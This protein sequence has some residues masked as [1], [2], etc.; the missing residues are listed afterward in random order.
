MLDPGSGKAA[1]DLGDAVTSFI[2]TGD[3]GA[4]TLMG[5]EIPASTATSQ[6]S[7]QE[8]RS[9]LIER[10]FTRLETLRD[11]LLNV[12]NVALR[13]GLIV[14]VTTLIREA[15]GYQL[16]LAWD[17]AD[18]TEATQAWASAAA[19]MLGPAMNVLG[20]VRDE[21]NGTGNWQTRIGRICLCSMTM[22]AT[23]AAY[24]GGALNDLFV[25]AMKVNIY[26]LL[27]EGMNAFFPLND[28]AGPSGLPAASVAM[29]GYGV[30]QTAL[31]EVSALLPIS[32]AGRAAAG[33]G[34]S[35][36]ADIWQSVLNAFGA[37]ADDTIESL[38]RYLLPV[39]SGMPDSL[40]DHVE[41]PEGWSVRAGALM[42]GSDRLLSRVL[43]ASPARISA[44]QT[45][46]ASLGAAAVALAGS[47]ADENAQS[48]LL[49]VAVGV[50][51]MLIYVPFIFSMQQ[52]S[53][54]WSPIDLHEVQ[55]P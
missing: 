35:L 7:L 36:T 13:T 20:F 40:P 30:M 31:A 4:L 23:L 53:N 16:Q 43:D 38:S 33:L 52:R 9:L 37:V 26:S 44:F 18:P 24:L 19:L 46:V 54:Q 12:A 49:S 42:P 17:A 2:K 3:S 21:L 32:G 27:R 51:L 50:V 11:P 25:G 5:V 22:G 34:Y 45:L 47:G 41:Q 6:H 14:T 8:R 29:V 15:V 28:N 48:H 39:L 1:D 55:S 10:I